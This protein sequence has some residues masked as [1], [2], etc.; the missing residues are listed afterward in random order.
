M[1]VGGS[2][3]ALVLVLSGPNLHRL[4]KREP[5]IYGARTLDDLAALCRSIGGEAGLEVDFRQTNAEHELLEWLHRAADEEVPVVLNAAAWT[6]T[7]AAIGDACAQLTAPLIEVHLS[8]VFA[9]E[10]FRHHSYVSP[11]ASG[12]VV[13]L[14]FDGYA[15]ALRHLAR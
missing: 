8:N 10:A 9:R 14:G 4:G 13:G 3:Q 5:E 15:M 11:H 12:V 1:A 7:S 6:H 2:R